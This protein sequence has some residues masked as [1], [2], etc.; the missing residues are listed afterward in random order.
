MRAAD[1]AWCDIVVTDKQCMMKKFCDICAADF[2]LWDILV[3]NI[4]E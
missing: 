4:I 2:H 1:V 3:T